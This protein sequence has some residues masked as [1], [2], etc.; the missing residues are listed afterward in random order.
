MRNLADTINFSN[1]YT[2]LHWGR[3]ASRHLGLFP[4]RTRL[5]ALLRK[6]AIWA[7]RTRQRQALARLDPRL[8]RDIGVDP[9]SARREAS[10]PC[11]RA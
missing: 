7:A 9:V 2:S 10:K 5:R 3:P 1:N 4:R 11:W 8:L 6:G